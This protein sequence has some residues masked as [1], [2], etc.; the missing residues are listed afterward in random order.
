MGGNHGPDVRWNT[1]VPDGWATTV[2]AWPWR[3]WKQGDADYGWRK[4]GKCPRCEHTISV[5]QELVEA[6]RPVMDPTVP[7]Y[8][9]CI[10]P[11]DGRPAEQKSGCGVGAANPVRIRAR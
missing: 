3:D 11:H 6:I 10:Y 8:C 7:A 9:N 4:W 2:E 5:Y 1:D